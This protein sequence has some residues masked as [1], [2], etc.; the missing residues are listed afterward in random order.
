MQKAA[1]TI[2]SIDKLNDFLKLWTFLWHPT[3]IYVEALF[4][5]SA[6]NFLRDESI[7]FNF[8]EVRGLF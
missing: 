7:C 6:S 8:I 3:Y 5:T 1:S 4:V 2:E